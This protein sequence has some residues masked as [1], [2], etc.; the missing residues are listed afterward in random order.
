MATPAQIAANRRNARKS[1]GPKS[2]AG[3]KRSSKNAYTYGLTTSPTGDEAFDIAGLIFGERWPDEG[4][5]LHHRVMTL[6]RTEAKRHHVIEQQ[7][8]VNTGDIKDP[9]DM[10]S[11]IEVT[12]EILEETS[13]KE[14]R[15]GERLLRRL[16]LAEA[17]DKRKFHKLAMRYVSEAEAQASKAR[18]AYAN[19]LKLDRS[20]ISDGTVP[21]TGLTGPTGQGSED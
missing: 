15:T 2:I 1:T 10:S 8:K 18:R 16:I 21:R 17:R 7:R 19:G 6:A 9:S 4:S 20:K 14:R 5:D 11:L 13:G 3:K 12:E